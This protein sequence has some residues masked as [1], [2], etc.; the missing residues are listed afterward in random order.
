MA[1]AGKSRRK[2]K[3]R[4][5]L[6]TGEG[7]RE[8]GT[9]FYRWTVKGKRHYVYAKTLE[10]LREKEKEI[11]KDKMD[12]IKAEARYTTVNDLFDLW[13]VLKRGLKDNTFE[14]YKYM[15]DTFVRPTFGKQRICSLKKSDVKRFYNYLADERGLQAATIDNIHTVLHQVLDM[16]VDD[17]YIR[18]NPSNNVLKELKQSHVFQTEKRRALTKAEQEL[19]LRFLKENHT[20]S[21]WYPIFAALVGT[22]LRVGELTGLR[23]CDLDMENGLIDINHTLVYYCHREESAKNGCYYNVNTPKT[24][25]SNRQVPM[26]GFV[27]EA[28]QMEREYQELTGITCAVTIDGYSDFVFLNRNGSV[29]NQGTLNKV[30]RRIIRDCN[31]AELLKSE[32]PDVLLPH[33]SCHSLRHTFT[34]RMCEAGVN[35]KVIQDTLGHQDISTTMNIYADATKELKME[36]FAGLDQF[37]CPV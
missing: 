21:R 1:N 22:G 18:V 30:I 3:N 36:A 8:N 16:A 28:F 35:V 15:Y 19:L 17:E 2:D 20:Y 5:V 4:V 33:F 32:S 24:K 23:W 11:A 27:K 37:F 13:K 14:N 31:D 34:T 29:Y 6:K 12:G 7:Q 25:N 26:L 10:E 9:Y